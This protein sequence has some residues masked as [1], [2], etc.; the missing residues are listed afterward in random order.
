MNKF[1]LRKDLRIITRIIK[2]T[3]QFSPSYLYFVFFSNLISSSIPFINIFGIKF[4]IN[5]F[6][7]ER[8]IGEL[9]VII[10]IMIVSTLVL[11]LISHLMKSTLMIKSQ[12]ISHCFEKLLLEKSITM[13]FIHTENPDVIA[14]NEQAMIALSQN[15]TS[16][17]IKFFQ[18]MITILFSLIIIL[19]FNYW[20]ILIVL[21]GALIS[22]FIARKIEKASHNYNEKTS[23]AL[24]SFN[25][26][27]HLGFD[28]KAA[29]DIRI[30]NFQPLIEGEMNASASE[31]LYFFK[32]ERKVK[33]R[34]FGLNSIIIHLQSCA[35]YAFLIWEFIRNPFSIGSLFLYVGAVAFL[36]TALSLFFDVLGQLRSIC[37]HFDPYI[38]YIN[39]SEADK[40]KASFTL[41][42]R[43]D[44]EFKNVSFHYPNSDRFILR[45][46]SFQLNGQGR[47][48]IVGENKAG[49]TTLVKLLSKLYRPTEGKI[50]VNGQD[51]NDINDEQY[52]SFMSV[53]FQD[54]NI[55]SFTI[56]E[57]VSFDSA[58]EDAK[59]RLALKKVDFPDKILVMKNGMDTMINNVF[60]PDGIELIGSNI[61]QVALARAIYKDAPLIILDEPTSPLDHY[62]EHA[63]YRN[64]DRAIGDSKVIYTTHR[65][66]SCKFADRIIVLEKG[67]IVEEGTHEQL[68]K[69]Q[70]KYFEMFSLQV[71]LNK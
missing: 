47:F 36:S 9:Y 33:G 16:G 64:F 4:L 49:K 69:K 32:A 25:Y 31:I 50:L 68:I 66:S 71:G 54:F 48:A 12:K 37:R 15:V 34:Y 44:I 39:L 22:L 17:I 35:V 57:N 8:R 11:S 42:N 62:E 6:L 58:A 30:Y 7:G 19:T 61:Q 56:K 59:V 67:E 41:N 53:V 21:I 65:V 27:R 10:L 13:D 51:I 26:Y 46:V 3:H 45:N 43:F 1:S 63:I 5:E 55:F 23:S 18:V 14:L 24:K 70:G 38:N 20:I 40:D 29:K 28:Y 2:L 52:H 60:E